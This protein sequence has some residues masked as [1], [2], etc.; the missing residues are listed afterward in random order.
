[1]AMFSEG[2]LT[3]PDIWIV[4]TIIL[5][6]FISILLNPLV[7]RHNLRKK[8]SIARDLYMALSTTDFLSCIVLPLTF[9]IGIL[10]PKEEQCSQDHNVTFCQTDYYKYNR[11]A[12]ITEKAVGSVAW[13]LIFSPL[14]ITSVL[15]MSRWYQISYPLR[16]LSR[17]AVEITLAVLLLL[18]AIYFLAMV[19]SDS[20]EKPTVLKINIQTVW[21]SNGLRAKTHYFL[22]EGIQS[23]LLTSLSTVASVFTV[24][25]VVNSQAVSGDLE[26]SARRI[27]STIKIAL[28]NVG[29]VVYIGIVIFM[30]CINPNSR[31]FLFL[32]TVSFCIP[33]LQST[34]NPVI[35]TVLSRGILNNNSRV[36]GEN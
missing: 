24:W 3:C 13:Y 19:F 26:I 28:L 32:Q 9:C 1:M 16:V 11:T 2:G 14:S 12:T 31:Q 5:I 10:R 4:I 36:R 30:T 17:T 20:P 27:K 25:N 21:N 6:A 29:N 23:L 8:R 33:I 34:Y 18:Q 7:L 15:A 22:M 35:Y